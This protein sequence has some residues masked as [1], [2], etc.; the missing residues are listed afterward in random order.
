MTTSFIWRAS[1][2][3]SSK[4]SPASTLSPQASAAAE[5]ARVQ[6]GHRTRVERW[7]AN[8]VGVPIAVI[9]PPRPGGLYTPDRR[10]KFLHLSVASTIERAIKWK[11]DPRMP[12]G[13]GDDAGTPAR[14]VVRRTATQCQNGCPTTITVSRL[15][16]TSRL[17]RSRRNGRHAACWLWPPACCRRRAQNPLHALRRPHEIWLF[18]RTGRKRRSRYDALSPQPVPNHHY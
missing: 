5:H 2:K 3:P 12:S 18:R 14:R 6:S 17:L 8:P 1:H 11:H 7:L 13:S 16:A 9:G 10:G 4:K 15:Q